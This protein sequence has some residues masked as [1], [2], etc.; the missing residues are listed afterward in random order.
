MAA[1]DPGE[2]VDV[3]G[4][5]RGE[6]DVADPGLLTCTGGQMQHFGFAQVILNKFFQIHD[7]SGAPNLRMV[8]IWQ[9]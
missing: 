5:I 3:H 8:K 1:V 9:L 7:C 4:I 2:P 6:P